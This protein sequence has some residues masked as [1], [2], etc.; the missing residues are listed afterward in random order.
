M[1]QA[2]KDLVF[3]KEE[4]EDQVIAKLRAL[5]SYLDGDARINAAALSFSGRGGQTGDQGRKRPSPAAGEEKAPPRKKP[6][7]HNVKEGL[8]TT[9]H[10][11]SPLC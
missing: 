3:W 7:A 8:F 2:A 10:R 4:V 9:N 11:G 6:Y 5:N 1:D